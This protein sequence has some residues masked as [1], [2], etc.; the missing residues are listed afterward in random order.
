[1]QFQRSFS[2]DST[3]L[4]E[5]SDSP[6]QKTV[7]AVYAQ[8]AT[9]SVEFRV[10]P[11]TPAASS[12]R[13]VDTAAACANDLRPLDIA[14]HVRQLLAL[15][16]SRGGLEGQLRFSD[17]DW[18]LSYFRVNVFSADTMDDIWVALCDAERCCVPPPY[19]FQESAITGVL[20]KFG[21]RVPKG[22]G[23]QTP[24]CM[25]PTA[26]SSR[27]SYPTR[28]PSV[29]SPAAS[30]KHK[31]SG[32]RATSPAVFQR[33]LADVETARE[34]QRLWEDQQRAEEERR[35][36]DGCTFAPLLHSSRRRGGEHDAGQS[37]SRYSNPTRS[38]QLRMTSRG[39]A[40]SATAESAAAIDEE[41]RALHTS[42][43][44]IRR[45]SPHRVPTQVPVGFVEAVA[46]LRSSALQHSK[47]AADFPSSL[48]SGASN[49]ARYAELQQSMKDGTILR[50]PVPS[51]DDVVNVRLSSL[52]KTM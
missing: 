22:S 41:Q 47:R 26:S 45:S 7:A 25:T 44:A 52:P 39:A 27:K 51:L 4:S 35:A 37:S 8:L 46:R 23:K 19:V 24:R 34:R 13:A 11:I 2:P 33:L 14:G 9:P 17:L 6:R 31:P 5:A 28:H 43:V 38:S 30:K 15:P 42:P 1:M 49:S 3:T 18:V 48:R 40:R 32:G 12:T 16:R 50:I 36:T 10:A 29:Q 20:E 21:A